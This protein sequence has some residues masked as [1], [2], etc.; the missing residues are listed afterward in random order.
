MF[1]FWYFS[2]HTDH[3]FPNQFLEIVD[4]DRRIIGL[5][6]YESKPDNQSSFSDPSIELY[7]PDD[8]R[9]W[10]NLNPEPKNIICYLPLSV[11][12]ELSFRQLFVSGFDIVDTTPE[13]IVMPR[14]ITIRCK[15]LSDKELFYLDHSYGKNGERIP[16]FNKKEVLDFAGLIGSARHQFAMTHLIKGGKCFSMFNIADLSDQYVVQNVLEF[17]DDAVQDFDVFSAY[18]RIRHSIVTNIE[19]FQ[20][21]NYLVQ[22][23]TLVGVF[24]DL[25]TNP[26]HTKTKLLSNVNLNLISNRFKSEVSGTFL[27]LPINHRNRVELDICGHRGHKVSKVKQLPKPVSIRGA[28]I[29]DISN[30]LTPS[31][32]YRKSPPKSKVGQNTTIFGKK[33]WG[34]TPK[35]L[36]PNHKIADVDINNSTFKIKDSKKVHFVPKQPPIQVFQA[37]TSDSSKTLDLSADVSVP[38]PAP[39]DIPNPTVSAAPMSAL[40]TSIDY[41]NQ[42]PGPSNRSPTTIRQSVAPKPQ[43]NPVPNPINDPHTVPNPN[44]T[45]YSDFFN[46]WRLT[47]VYKGPNMPTINDTNRSTSS[48]EDNW[49]NILGDLHR[50]QSQF[51]NQFQQL[52]KEYQSRIVSNSENDESLIP[53]PSRAVLMM[54]EIN[55]LARAI[56]NNSSDFDKLRDHITNCVFGIVST[57]YSSEISRPNI[58]PV[59][60][61]NFTA[62][63]TFTNEILA[64]LDNVRD[65]L[66]NLRPFPSHPNDN[67]NLKESKLLKSVNDFHDG[68]KPLLDAIVQR[69]EATRIEIDTIINEPG[70]SASNTPNVTPPNQSTQKRDKDGNFE[71][72][73]DNSSPNGDNNTPNNDANN[74]APVMEQTIPSDVLENRCEPSIQDSNVSKI[75]S[76]DLALIDSTNRPPVENVPTTQ[77]SAPIFD[78]QGNELPELENIPD[79]DIPRTPERQINLPVIEI[80]KSPKSKSKSTKKKGRFMISSDSDSENKRPSTSLNQSSISSRTRKRTA[81]SVPSSKTPKRKRT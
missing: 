50:F 55:L 37:L 1:Y 30:H 43:P 70:S 51:K 2:I 61:S 65:S 77:S 35:N 13:K 42:S 78:E 57:F 11:H 63:P 26:S 8:F 7:A 19:K 25:S 31:P 22:N 49:L 56:Q 14:D 16:K 75:P 64:F 34:K 73:S 29:W 18:K 20:T 36:F 4:D 45:T 41:Q 59:D 67:H 23:G 3:L 53:E 44:A 62:T 58:N 74:Q 76:S 9:N 80:K 48:S 5:V 52:L 28:S 71:F 47:F 33:L 68:I 66:M 6:L 72:K 81:G 17:P 69:F 60:F 38:G 54:N 79:E 15:P 27:D 39:T 46:N 24:Y 40:N 10:R 12:F 21:D 32:V